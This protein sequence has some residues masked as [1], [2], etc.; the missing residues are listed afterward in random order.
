M[1]LIREDAMWFGTV[2]HS[3]FFL[4]VVLLL[5]KYPGKYT[6]V[7]FCKLGTCVC[8]MKLPDFFVFCLPAM[9]WQMRLTV[10]WGTRTRTS[11]SSSLGRVGLGKPVSGPR[12]TVSQR[13]SNPG[14]NWT[15]ADPPPFH[16]V[17][18]IHTMNVL[19]TTC[20][21]QFMP[22]ERVDENTT[23]CLTSRCNVGSWEEMLLPLS[24]T[25]SNK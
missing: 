8:N 23:C 24:S 13:L 11:A 21:I 1:L 6:K 7:R 4:T 5:P 12:Q 20:R 10:L 15:H 16:T 17:K 9:L 19:S 22:Q 2:A 3:I 18:H 14:E 25:H